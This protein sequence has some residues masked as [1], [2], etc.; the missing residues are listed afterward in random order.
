MSPLDRID[1]LLSIA[2]DKAL[3]PSALAVAVALAKHVNQQTGDARPAKATV[4]D[5]VK[6]DERAVRRMVLALETAGWLAVNKTSGRKCCIYK[7]TNPGTI[8]RDQPGHRNPGSDSNPGTATRVPV[9]VNPGR[10]VPPT[11]APSPPEQGIE[12]GTNKRESRA[13]CFSPPTVA[14]V[15]AYCYERGN[16]IDAQRFVDFYETRG[17]MAG[18]AKVKDWR[19]CVRTWES[20]N[21][22]SSGQGQDDYA[23]RSGPSPSTGSPEGWAYAREI[24]AEIKAEEAGR[25]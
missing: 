17:W 6:T 13:R 19:A 22:K 8:T 7:P 10:A 25:G 3:P 12:Q 18:K 20:R 24:E 11:R 1:W 4:A 2:G 14:D 16:G 23:M 21:G 15:E 5:L 9:V